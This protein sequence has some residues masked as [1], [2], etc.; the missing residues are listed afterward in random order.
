MDGRE[1]PNAKYINAILFLCQSLG[2]SV[3]GKKKLYKLLYYVDF[4]HYEYK[5][6]MRSI[7]GGEYVAWSMGPVPKDRGEV[8][9]YMVQQHLLKRENIHIPNMNDAVRYTALSEPDMDVFDNDERFILNRVVRKYGGL[10]GRQLE[11][12]T[13]AEAPYIGTVQNEVIDYGLAFYRETAFDDVPA[14][15]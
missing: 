9:D 2:G 7:T 1:Q 14:T 12:L 6:S 15:A 13:H 3:I 8:L 5:E 11:I 4:D 10:T